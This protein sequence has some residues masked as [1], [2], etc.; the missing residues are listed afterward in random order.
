MHNGSDELHEHEIEG[1]DP[2]SARVFR[3]FKT[4]MML[5]R[6]LMAKMFADE[7]IHPAQGM[8]LRALSGHD[9]ISQSDLAQMLR[10][11][12]PTVTTMLQKMEAAGMIERRPDEHDARLTRIH[13]TD[14]GRTMSE[15][16]HAVFGKS[17]AASI[18]QM[19]E[20]DRGELERLLN[21]LNAYVRGAIETYDQ[22]G[23]ERKDEH[24]L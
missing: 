10:V 17:I 21:D 20:D 8:C 14:E 23:D 18:G 7:T 24:S 6:R 15:R 5:N 9:G 22:A 2:L 16:I 4:Q 12:R 3:A 13:L 1:V 19:P 11:S